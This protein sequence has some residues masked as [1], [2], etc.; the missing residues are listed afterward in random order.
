M[1]SSLPPKVRR[2]IAQRVRSG[3]YQSARD[4]LIAALAGLDQ[5]ER[6]AKLSRRELAAIFPGIDDKI[7]RGIAQADAG[8]LSDGEAVFHHLERKATAARRRSA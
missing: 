7:A 1:D 2:L 8:K 3:K 4:V 6:L 5:Q